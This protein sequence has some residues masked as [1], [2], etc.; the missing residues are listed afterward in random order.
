MSFVLWLKKIVPS[1]L[2]KCGLALTF[3]HPPCLVPS[4]L[5]YPLLL[6]P[7]HTS[8]QLSPSR[9]RK[10][11]YWLMWSLLHFAC[12]VQS[13]ATTAQVFQKEFVPIIGIFN[14]LF[15]DKEVC[16]NQPVFLLSFLPPTWGVAKEE[17]GLGMRQTNLFSVAPGCA[18]S[19]QHQLCV[20]DCSCLHLAGL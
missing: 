4:S 19:V 1:K 15:Q 12:T 3:P 7:P 10:G 6:P 11:R 8:H 2:K 20:P 17:W 18:R 5:P 9:L 13:K 14:L 16:I